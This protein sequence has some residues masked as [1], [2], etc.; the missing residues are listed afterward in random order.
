MLDDKQTIISVVNALTGRIFKTKYIYGCL[1]IAYR[2]FKIMLSNL[3]WV[4]SKLLYIV[5]L[6]IFF[7][8]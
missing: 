2:L 1:D 3:I 4:T 6:R 5:Y 7:P 8:F